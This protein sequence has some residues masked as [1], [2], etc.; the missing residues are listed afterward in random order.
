MP[1]RFPEQSYM[2]KMYQ[3]KIKYHGKDKNP[4]KNQPC[5]IKIIKQ[6]MDEYKNV[7]IQEGF[8]YHN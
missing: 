4:N 1:Q 6:G 7:V 2:Y 8:E 3:N 5:N